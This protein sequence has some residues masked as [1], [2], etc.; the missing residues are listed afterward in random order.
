MRKDLK[1]HQLVF[2]GFGSG[3]TAYVK[4]ILNETSFNYVILDQKNEYLAFEKNM[5]D[6]YCSL[7]T[8]KNVPEY[9]WFSVLSEI[10]C[11][12]FG[13]GQRASMILNRVLEGMSNGKVEIDFRSLLEVLEREFEKRNERMNY[14]MPFSEQ[15][16]YHVLRQKFASWVRKPTETILQQKNETNRLDLEVLR[17][18]EKSFLMKLCAARLFFER[19]YNANQNDPIILVVEDAEL[20]FPK[21]QKKDVLHIHESVLETMVREGRNYQMYCIFVTSNEQGISQIIKDNLYKRKFVGRS[22]PMLDVDTVKIIFETVT[23][24]LP[25]KATIA[26][27]SA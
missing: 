13:L 9:I 3:K 12:T 22:E 11:E 7:N 24:S 27:L 19:K 5:S 25:C 6:V 4:N 2:G 18:D 21:E 8:P 17:T 26:F 14:R 20:L 1:R 15:E 10:F 16:N 23:L